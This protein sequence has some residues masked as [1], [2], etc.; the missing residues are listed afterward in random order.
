MKNLIASILTAGML[1]MA[2]G[3]T[4]TDAARIY[5]A[6][7]IVTAINEANDTFTIT[8]SIGFTWE[9]EGVEDWAIGD[10]CNLLMYNNGT[11]EIADDI[12]MQ[13]VYFRWNW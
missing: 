7:G 11:P 2:G 13:A 1:T 8:D 5:P 4:Q 6:T 12:I 10:A 9:M 3:T